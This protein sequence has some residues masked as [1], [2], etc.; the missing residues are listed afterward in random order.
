MRNTDSIFTKK[1]QKI[2]TAITQSVQLVFDESQKEC[3]SEI[4][5]DVY[6]IVRLLSAHRSSLK[7]VDGKWKRCYPYADLDISQYPIS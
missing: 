2:R 4:W 6:N 3:N 1:I 5:I 7:K